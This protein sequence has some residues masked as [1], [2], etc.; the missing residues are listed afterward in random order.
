M[1]VLNYEGVNLLDRAAAERLARELVLDFWNH[2]AKQQQAV[3]I[4]FRES[5]FDPFAINSYISASGVKRLVRGWF[6]ISSVHEGTHYEA[7]DRSR[8]FA[9]RFN[10]E[11][12]RKIYDASDGD[13]CKAW[14]AT[15][16]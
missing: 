7:R 11:V 14:P 13:F 12:A 3:N 5:S 16:G 10:L 2:P 15:C 6:Q 1:D 4:I 9:P 8:L